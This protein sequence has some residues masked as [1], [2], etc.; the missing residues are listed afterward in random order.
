MEPPPELVPQ[1]PRSPG[2]RSWLVL[3]AGLATLAAGIVLIVVGRTGG[4]G[5]TTPSVVVPGAS[6]TAAL[7][8]GIPQNGLVL[9]DPEAPVTLVEWADLQCPYCREW[10]AAAFP[11]LVREYVRT[12][13][14]QIAYRGLAFLGPDSTRALQIALA[15]ALQD[16][17]WHVV[18][19]LYRN[20]GVENSGWATDEL[21]RGVAGSVNGLDR[22]RVLAEMGSADIQS[23]ISL[24]AQAG[25]RAKV[26][27][28]PTFDIGKTG[29][30]QFQRLNVT[31]LTP[32]AF[33][34]AIEKL[35]GS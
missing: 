22:G 31:N 29:A 35:L 4:D 30:K 26:A 9:G 21:L 18:D 12:G 32:A 15:A 8:D 20:Q 24:A 33:A 34:P 7:L 2:R 3:A 19:L 13:K 25:S 10:A 17:L 1:P 14:L 23:A 27:G 16:R 11:A 6:E 28:T 5:A